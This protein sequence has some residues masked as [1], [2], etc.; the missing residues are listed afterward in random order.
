MCIERGF[1][2]IVRRKKDSEGLSLIKSKEDFVVGLKAAVQGLE[3]EVEIAQ[4]NPER[5]E[6]VDQVLKRKFT[7]ALARRRQYNLG[8]Y[9]RYFEESGAGTE[10]LEVFIKNIP[11]APETGLYVVAPVYSSGEDLAGLKGLIVEPRRL[12][13][14]IFEGRLITPEAEAGYLARFYLIFNEH[15]DPKLDHVGFKAYEV[16]ENARDL[17]QLPGTLLISWKRGR[18]KAVSWKTDLISGVIETFEQKE[19]RIRREDR[20]KK[21]PS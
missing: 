18:G 20:K 4:R 6:S 17:V 1:P 14:R 5:G 21:S 19:R 15:V 3:L 9:I 7:G 16:P 8:S 10:R 12:S 13:R 11:S 2:Y